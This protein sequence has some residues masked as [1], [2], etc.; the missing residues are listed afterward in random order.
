MRDLYSDDR[1]YYAVQQ[2]DGNFVVYDVSIQPWVP[3][4][5]RW[6]HERNHTPVVDP[7]DIPNLPPASPPSV[8]RLTSP[9]NGTILNR[10][11]SY[12]PQTY[13]AGSV[14][15]YTFCGRA[16]DIPLLLSTDLTT[17]NVQQVPSPLPPGTTEGW[18]WDKYGRIYYPAGKRLIRMDPFRQMTSDVVVAELALDGDF[19]L[20]QC[21]S[22][23]DGTVH[24]A[25]VRRIVSDGAYPKVSTVIFTPNGQRLF[26]PGDKELDESQVTAD[27]KYLIIKEG[28]DNRIVHI[29]T[30]AEHTISNADGAL[31]HSDV[32]P[33]F[34]IGEDDQGG[35]CVRWDFNPI[36]KRP[37]FQT[38][39]L[40]HVSIQ[41]GKCL[42]SDKTWLY[43]VDPITGERTSVIQHGS[44]KTD[45]GDYDYQ[46]FANLDPSAKVATYAAY[47]NG[48]HDL[49]LVV[50]P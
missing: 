37:F 49:Y 41:N 39:N 13:V 17:G 46:V 35:A 33:S 8:I 48:R 1:H 36:R 30:Y 40:G 44:E 47:N 16:G 32:G 11:Y 2:D 34:A 20:W 4:W 22:S 6:S 21:H 18:Y 43:L 25:T 9:A 26:G 5:D 23:D 42:I 15:A 31:G 10:G 50:L 38:W 27:G 7:G 28:N 24:S 19:D 3:I 12:W 45:G 14:V 29:P